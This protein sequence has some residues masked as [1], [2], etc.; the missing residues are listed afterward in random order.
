MTR[1]ALLLS[2]LSLCAASCRREPKVSVRRQTVPA[3]MPT[4]S[5]VVTIVEFSDAGER[6]TVSQIDRVEKTEEEWREQLSVLSYTVTREEGTERPFT[7]P[8]LKEHRAGI[9]RCICCETAVFAS[10]T[11]FDSGTGWPS[12]WQPIAPEN[13]SEEI[14]QSWGMTRTAVS[15]ARCSAHL[16][17]VF[18]DGPRPT[19]LRYC[20]NSAAMI[21]VARA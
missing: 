9:F 14:D 6:T 13:I 18:T 10:E 12:F 2:A 8:L 21:F 4:G 5:D 19:G 11:K 17:H 3:P 16:G 20:I 15:C 1:R 7:G